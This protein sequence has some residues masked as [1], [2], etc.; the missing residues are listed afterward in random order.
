MVELAERLAASLPGDL[1]SC[2]FV[3]TGT[4]A[5]DLAVQIARVVTGNHGVVVTERVVPR[6]LRPGRQASTDSYPESERPDWLGVVEPPNTYRGPFRRP[7]PS[8]ALDTR[9]SS[10]T[11]WPTSP[12]AGTAS[13]AC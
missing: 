9:G 6:Q 12:S 3:C 5:N 13:P 11:R 4:E 8:S 1:S 10:T 2:Y 7:S